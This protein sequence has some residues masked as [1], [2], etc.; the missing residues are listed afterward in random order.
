MV[1]NGFVGMSPAGFFTQTCRVSTTDSTA[2]NLCYLLF[3][4]LLAC[5]RAACRLA[6]VITGEV[7]RFLM[8][9]F[10]RVCG[11]LML[12]LASQRFS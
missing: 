4:K 11:C 5:D 9:G 10:G 8:F 12:V 7:A 1:N 6:W 2:I 3:H